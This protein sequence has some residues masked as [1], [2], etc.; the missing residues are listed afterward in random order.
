LKAKP[1]LGIQFGTGE[2]TATEDLENTGTSDPSK[3]VQLGKRFID[4][5]VERMMIE[6]EGIT[7]NVKSWRTDVI[8]TIMKELPREK[9]MLEGKCPV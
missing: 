7:E 8:Q 6:S 3:A 9:V 4:A 1:E 2:D 5:G